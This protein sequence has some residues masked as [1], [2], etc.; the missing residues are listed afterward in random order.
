[1]LYYFCSLK[2]NLGKGQGIL[3]Y[4]NPVHTSIFH[5]FC[6]FFNCAFTPRFD[7]EH[8]PYYISWCYFLASW[9]VRV[10]EMNGEGTMGTICLTVFIFLLL[11]CFCQ[12]DD[13]LTSARPL[14]PGDLLISK[15]G[16][17][18]LG[19]FSPAGS[20]ESLYVGIWFHGIPER[21]RAVVWVANRDNPTTTASTPTLAI[22]GGGRNS[23]LGVHVYYRN[24]TIIA[25]KR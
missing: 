9:L 4:F 19:F 12:S 11:I 1:M 7:L 3:K 25:R 18:A 10:S 17:F 22:S 20:N 8:V 5:P 6:P 14:S 23:R 13:Q 24:R 15:N 2:S 21:S 16:V